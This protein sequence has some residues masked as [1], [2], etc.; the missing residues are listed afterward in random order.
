MSLASKKI[1]WKISLLISLSFLIKILRWKRYKKTHL[2]HK[3][4]KC[5]TDLVTFLSLS[6]VRFLYYMGIITWEYESC[7]IPWFLCSFAVRLFY[8]CRPAV[9]NLFA[10]RD[11]RFMCHTS[12]C[13][14]IAIRRENKE[15]KFSVMQQWYH[16][17]FCI[18]AMETCRSNEMW[19]TFFMTI[20]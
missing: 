2:S 15:K 18:R 6:F 3:K 8:R 11:G 10:D 9:R 13:Y 1:F 17:F 5:V 20:W 19:Y 7:Q 4:S 14:D 16:S 12:F